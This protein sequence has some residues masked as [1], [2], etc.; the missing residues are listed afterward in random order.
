MFAEDPASAK[1][2]IWSPPSR[3]EMLNVLKGLNKDGSRK[4]KSGNEQEEEEYDLL[5]IGAGATGAG[6]AL[7]AATRG[8]KVA[9][10]ERDDFASGEFIS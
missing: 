1:G 6:C 10:V 4:S 7:D 5:I 8:L 2:K 3:K 9:C